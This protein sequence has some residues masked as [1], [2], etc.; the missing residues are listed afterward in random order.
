MTEVDDDAT[1]FL[2]ALQFGAGLGDGQQVDRCFLRGA[3]DLEVEPMLQSLLEE[4]LPTIRSTGAPSDLAARSKYSESIPGGAAHD[5]DLFGISGAAVGE[6]DIGKLYQ[7][8][9]CDTRDGQGPGMR[10]RVLFLPALARR[11]LLD[12]RDVELGFGL[13]EG[14][15]DGQKGEGK[16]MGVHGGVLN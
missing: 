6:H 2:G 16:Q 15:S 14:G 10:D 7:L 8:L 12:G 4:R 11:V 3:V 13:G 9:E 1:A 5:V